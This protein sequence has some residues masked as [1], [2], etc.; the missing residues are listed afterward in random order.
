MTALFPG[1]K[2]YQSK[3]SGTPNRTTG[4][5]IAESSI[6]V[7]EIKPLF[8]QIQ[9]NTT[10]TAKNLTVLPSIHRD[11]NVIRQNI[12]KLLK[13]EK[14]DARTKADMYFKAA[15]KREEMYESQLEKLRERSKSPSRVGQFRFSRIIKKY[16]TYYWCR[17]SNRIS[18]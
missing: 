15:A 6:D 9:Y 4:K 12:V 18:I 14:I 11:F 16:F 2:P 1:L 3:T 7:S 13:L 8:E 5:S 10:L 17:R